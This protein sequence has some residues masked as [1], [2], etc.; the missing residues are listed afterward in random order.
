MSRCNEIPFANQEHTFRILAGATTK[1]LLKEVNLQ[2]V[3]LPSYEDSLVSLAMRFFRKSIGSSAVITVLALKLRAGFGAAYAIDQL[4][5]KRVMGGRLVESIESRMR[6][7]IVHML[8]NDRP[9]PTLMY[10]LQVGVCE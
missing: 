9:V 2:L 8:K 10:N 6:A 3:K 1:C 4:I 5:L 7:K